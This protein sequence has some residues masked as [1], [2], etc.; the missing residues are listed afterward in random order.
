MD[1][2]LEFRLGV[3][4]DSSLSRSVFE[5]V[6]VQFSV[7]INSRTLLHFSAAQIVDHDEDWK[8]SWMC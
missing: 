5:H 3:G 4:L 2:T 1:R 8:P 7:A 6:I